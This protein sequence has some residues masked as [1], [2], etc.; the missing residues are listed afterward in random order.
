MS[1]FLRARVSGVLESIRKMERRRKL[2]YGI[3]SVALLAVLSAWYIG[4]RQAEAATPCGCW[5][6]TTN[7]ANNTIEVYD[8]VIYNWNT[9]TAKKWSWKPSTA[10]GYS[11]TEVGWWGGPSDVKLRN[12]SV[13][14]GQWVVATA[15]RLA[16]IASYPGGVRKWAVDVGAGSNPHSAELLPNGNLAVAATDAGSVRVYPTSPGGGVP[17]EYPLLASHATLWDPANEVLW[18]IGQDPVTKEHILT[19]LTVGGTVSAPTLTED[20]SRR[21]I[22]PT[23][24]GHDVSA[25]YYDTNK[26]WVSTNAA[27]YIYDKT[28]KTFTSAPSGANRSFVK[29]VSNQPS[30]QIVETKADATKTPPGACTASGWCTDT[31]DFYA[32]NATRTVTGAAFYKARVWGPDYQ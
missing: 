21:S 18:V 1:V 19:A 4:V 14:G 10:L 5:I 27:V 24:W 22:L 2:A 13:W 32:P 20:L 7:Q 30:G 25:Y 8:P 16:T 11:T 3:L 17:G 15:G 28:A 6:V 26:L 31:V 9:A 23:P 12:N 29:G